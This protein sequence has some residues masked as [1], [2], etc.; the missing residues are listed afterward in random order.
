MTDAV[1]NASE[2]RLVV[3]NELLAGGVAEGIFTHAAYALARGGQTVARRTFGAADFGTIFDLASLTKPTAT[4][5][6]ILQLVERG[7]LHLRE[8]VPAFFEAE[9]GALPHL[10][11]VQLHHLLTHTSGLPPIPRWPKEGAEAA[12]SEMV[13]AVVT[14]PLQRPP[15]NRYVYSDTGYILLGEIVARVSGQ[16]LGAYFEEN[17]GKPL[18]LRHTG[19]Q[20]TADQYGR[21]ASTG[22]DVPPGAAHDP[23]ARDLGG[24]SGHAGLFGT[25]DDV[26]TY[27]EAIRTGGAPILSRAAVAR[28]AMSQIAPAVG[29]QS[30]GWFCRGNDLRPAGDLFSDEAFGHSGF[31]GTLMLIDP[32]YE[33]TLVLLTNRVVNG[34]EDGSRFLRLRRCWLNAMAAALT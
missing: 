29:G 21:L 11:D 20:P 34:T 25:V 3:A 15:G 12:R 4:A 33:T 19:F 30:W 13:R 9:F 7:R 18:G 32:V 22:K 26:L 14:T 31:T 28:M 8:P 24:L 23:R 10:A 1:E 6:A 16:S 5:T 17:I 27:A 2:E